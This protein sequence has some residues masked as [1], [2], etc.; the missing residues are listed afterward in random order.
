MKENVNIKNVTIVL[1]RPKYPGNIG[2][3]ARCL[4]NMGIEKLSVICHEKPDVV[5]MKQMATH[6]A[7]DIIDNI[8][9]YENLQEA[10]VSFHYIIGTTARMGTKSARRPV[11]T[12]RESAI[13][14]V[15]T[16]RNNSIALV[17][18]PE[19]RGLTNEELK[20]CHSLVNIPTSDQFKSVNLSHAVM[21]CCYEIFV[22]SSEPVKR[23]TPR[24]AA[25]AEVEAMYAHLEKIFMEIG[26][27]KPENPEYRMMFIRRFFQRV[28]LSS[29]EVKIVRGICRHVERRVEK[30]KT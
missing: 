4:K 10:L 3:A 11:T 5:I 18:G 21:I 9:Y 12:P 16:S 24:L 7:A 22:A 14:L 6:V 30:Q 15:D 8:Q 20:Y 1:V 19:D 27:I 17:F 26:L 23:F 25:S 28:H 13:R 29:K 2:S